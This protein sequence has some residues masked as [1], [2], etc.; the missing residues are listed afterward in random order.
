MR[1]LENQRL[2]VAAPD[3]MPQTMEFTNTGAG[4]PASTWPSDRAWSLARVLRW[5]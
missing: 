1:V 3:A 5:L 4:T 2:A